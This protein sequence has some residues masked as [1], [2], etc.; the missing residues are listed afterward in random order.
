MSVIVETKLSG[1]NEVLMFIERLNKLARIYWPNEILD[2]TARESM[3]ILKSYMPEK[4][5]RMKSSVYIE[6]HP[7]KRIIVV[8]VPYAIYVDRGV[9]PR[10]IRPTRKKAL[11]FKKEGKLIVKGKVNWPGFRGREFLQKATKHIASWI[12]TRA[13]DYIEHDLDRWEWLWRRIHPTS[14]V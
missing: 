10:I 8:P 4:T 5:G 1:A 9:A 14:R 6:K 12:T 3:S 2:F 13:I 11:A 7:D